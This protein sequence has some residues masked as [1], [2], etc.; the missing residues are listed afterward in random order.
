MIQPDA[1][2]KGSIQAIATSA[3]EKKVEIFKELG[4]DLPACY[5]DG[6]KITWVLN[7]FLTNAIKYSPAESRIIVAVMA[8]DGMITFSVKDNGPGIE[9]KYLKRI[10]ERYFQVPGRSDAK[11]SGIGLAICK[12]FVEAM[13]GKVWVKS[14]F[15][16]GSTF[17]FQIP[18]V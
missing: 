3:K 8:A 18:I 7:N 9:E 15:G 1:I 6:D 14:V 11:S 4:D 5:A 16:E 10:F 17:G 2:V 12:E 13:G